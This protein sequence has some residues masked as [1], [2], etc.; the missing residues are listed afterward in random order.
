MNTL[1][2]PIEKID[3]PERRIRTLDRAWAENIGQSFLER[4]QI[5]PIIVRPKGLRYELV[6]GEHRLAGAWFIGWTEIASDVR[7]LTDDEALLVEIDENA[8][9]RELTSL[10]RDICFRE[11]KIVY[12]RLYPETA[13]GGDR[14]KSS[15]QNGDLIRFTKDAARKTG[16][17]ER[18]IQRSI[19]RVSAL[20][21]EA[22]EALKTSPIGK[23]ASEIEALSKMSPEDQIKIAGAIARGAKTLLNARKAVGLAPPTPDPVTF[24]CHKLEAAWARSPKA[25]REMFLD[26]ILPTWRKLKID[27]PDMETKADADEDA[28]DED[29]QDSDAGDEA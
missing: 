22:I 9:R 8:R 10:E 7:D 15:R 29:A 3:V 14:K 2:I 25:A 5:Q 13:H 11:R 27:I 4:G 1:P 26:R 20:V 12:E 19:A 18:T 21:P 28:Q 17:G 24:A 16:F 23:N 6:A